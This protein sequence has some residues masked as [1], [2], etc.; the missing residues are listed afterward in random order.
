MLGDLMGNMQEKQNAMQ[1]QLATVEIKETTDGL[2]VTANGAREI[3]NIDIDPALMEDK[4]QLEDLLVVT[5]NKVMER[6]AASEAEIS[7]KMISDLL[8]PGMEGLFGG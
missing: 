2:T 3:L 6:V 8:P 1:E 5:M 7:Q 4:E